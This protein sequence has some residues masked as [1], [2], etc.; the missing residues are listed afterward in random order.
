MEK[1]GPG[2]RT[3]NSQLYMTPMTQLLHVEVTILQNNLY[4]TKWL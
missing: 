2:K 3:G 4:G 1:D